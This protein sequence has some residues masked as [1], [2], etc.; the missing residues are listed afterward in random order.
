MYALRHRYTKDIMRFSQQ[1][2]EDATE[3]V[4]V[5]FSLEMNEY[6]P[7]WVVADEMVADRAARG[8]NEWYNAEFETPQNHWAGDLEVV[9]LVVKEGS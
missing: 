7:I 9:E 4:S 6:D 5:S 1:S 2:N 8:H 3:C